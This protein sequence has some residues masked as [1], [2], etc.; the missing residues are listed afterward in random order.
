MSFQIRQAQV[1]KWLVGMWDWNLR[2]SEYKILT[3]QLGSESFTQALEKHVCFSRY[4]L[5]SK[6]HYSL[7]KSYIGQLPSSHAISCKEDARHIVYFMCRYSQ[8][9]RLN[10]FKQCIDTGKEQQL[11]KANA[12]DRILGSF[13]GF[14]PPPTT[15]IFFRT[16][17]YLENMSRIW[18]ATGN[19]VFFFPF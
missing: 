14:S 9:N 2:H 8:P 5:E 19:Q 10:H 13:Q 12:T 11:R 4:P 1:L 17:F 18:K 15:L 16:A 6:F 7:M 3:Q